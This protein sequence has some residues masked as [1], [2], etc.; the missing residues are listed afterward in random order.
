L[1]IALLAQVE[2][3]H[4]LAF[5]HAEPSAVLVAVVWYGLRTDARRAA[6]FGLIAGACED[7][8]GGALTG[9]GTGGAW[10]IATTATAL[11]V[12]SLSQRFFADSIPV[13]GTAVAIATLFRR[14]LYWTVMSLEGYPRGYAQVHLHE[15]LWEALLNVVLVILLMLGARML[16]NRRAR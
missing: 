4:Y 10:T 11:L 6:L 12:S 5:R 9:A 7:L 2:L 15:A 16:E 8:L 13:V 1:A 14:L 3:M